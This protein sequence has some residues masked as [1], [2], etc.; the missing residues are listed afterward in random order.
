MT[1]FCARNVC[2]FIFS[3]SLPTS[4]EKVSENSHGAAAAAA[5]FHENAKGT[6]FNYVRYEEWN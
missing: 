1:L 2:L 6:E 5:H 4:S 3:D